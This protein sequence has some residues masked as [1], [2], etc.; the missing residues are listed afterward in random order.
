MALRGLKIHP[1]WMTVYLSV[2]VFML[3]LIHNIFTNTF[4]LIGAHYDN[5]MDLE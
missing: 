5:F 3:T 4:T 2:F 1:C